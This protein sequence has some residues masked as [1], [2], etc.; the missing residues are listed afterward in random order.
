MT[1]RE[2]RAAT[3]PRFAGLRCIFLLTAYR[4]TGYTVPV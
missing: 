2:R 4:N 1:V 3:K